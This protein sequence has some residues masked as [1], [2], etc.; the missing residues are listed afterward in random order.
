MRLQAI[1]KSKMSTGSRYSK[2]FNIQSIKFRAGRLYA[3]SYRKQKWFNSSFLLPFWEV[4]KNNIEGLIENSLSF[5]AIDHCWVLGKGHWT[6]HTRTTATPSFPSVS[7]VSMQGG[8]ASTNMHW[9]EASSL[10]LLW[11]PAEDQ[12]SQSY[13]ITSLMQ[14]LCKNVVIIWVFSAPL[15]QPFKSWGRPLLCKVTLKEVRTKINMLHGRDKIPSITHRK[16]LQL[17]QERKTNM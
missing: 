6:R 5:S 12:G 14:P 3:A 4:T 16:E 10:C 8:C 2:Y 13:Y 15:P 17:A 1:I 11:L 7:S 9:S